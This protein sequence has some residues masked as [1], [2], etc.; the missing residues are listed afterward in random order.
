MKRTLVSLL[1]FIFA[2]SFIVGCDSGPTATEPSTESP[3]EIAQLS[4]EEMYKSFLFGNGKAASMLPEFYGDVGPVQ[5]AENLSEDEVAQLAS[6]HIESM[7]TEDLRRAYRESRSVS[8]EKR[9]QFVDALAPKL[10]AA[11]K[12]SSPDFFSRFER[13]IKSGNQRDVQR[14][15]NSMAQV[16]VPAMSRVLDVP[17]NVILG[18]KGTDS[19]S[20]KYVVGALYV[21]VAVAAALAVAVT[22]VVEVHKVV[23]V[24]GVKN[25]SQLKNE[26]LVDR[27]AERFAVP[28]GA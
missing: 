26:I 14:A 22:A 23:S 16:T 1:G 8:P 3:D 21:A 28:S 18:K 20:Q 27:I 7:S 19:P 11:V 17:E 9:R 2:L 5:T 15:L 13:Q 24:E 6:K 10:V 12:E 4:G 25:T